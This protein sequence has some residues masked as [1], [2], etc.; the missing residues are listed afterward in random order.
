MGNCYA[1]N[2]LEKEIE[3]GMTINPLYDVFYEE[4]A[5][6]VAGA[7]IEEVAGTAIEE[8][9]GAAIEEVAG[10]AIEEAGAAIE[11]ARPKLNRKSKSEINDEF[12]NNSKIALQD[13]DNYLFGF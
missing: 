12:Y 8:V 2:K 9:A 10:A 7:A 1:K 3:F 6:E 11:V 5:N 4:E 13:L